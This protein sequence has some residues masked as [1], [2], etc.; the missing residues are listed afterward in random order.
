VKRNSRSPWLIRHRPESEAKMRLFCFPYAGGSAAVFREWSAR[1]DPLVEVWSVEYPGRGTRRSEKPFKQLSQLVDALL[2][3]MRDELTAPFAV[4][5]HSM[6]SLVALEILERLAIQGGPEAV[7]FFASAS[8]PPWCEARRPP[9]FDLPEPEFIQEVRALGGTPEELLADK[10]LTEL[11]LPFLRA[12]FQAAQTYSREMKVKL[13]CP[14]FAYGGLDDPEVSRE[15][16]SRWQDVCETSS[17]VRMF[18]GD[19]FYLHSAV[20]KVM[21]VLSRDLLMRMVEIGELRD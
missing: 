18:P 9:T 20:E 10:T 4:F 15:D 2:P 12:D 21:Q 1:L 3:D 14:I 7:C 11:F 6:G 13:R 19:H 5:G 8:R 16:L 17:V